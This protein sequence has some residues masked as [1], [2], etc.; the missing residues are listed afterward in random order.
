MSD[1]RTRLA[2]PFVALLALAAS[3]G[4]IVNEFTYDDR[5]I[6]ELNPVMRS[7]HG[8]WRVFQSSY[9]PKEWG[10]DGY[11][12]LTI[13]A[14]KIQ[15]AIGGGRPVV[16]HAANIALYAL[17]SVLVF[18]I[19]RRIL[20]LWAA[21]VVAAL[22]AAHPVHVEAV[23]NVVGQSEL[24][25]ASLL[26]GATLLYLRDRQRGELRPGTLASIV[27]LYVAACF[28]KEH[29]IVLPALL[30]ACELTVV[31]DPA[32]LRARLLTQR[33]L[34]L[35]LAVVAISFVMVRS[36]VLSD[37]ALAGF[38]PFTP[39]ASL[40]IS[41]RDRILTALGVVPQWVRLL[42]WPA[43]L[44]SEYGPPDIEI[45]QGFAFTQLPGLIVLASI[46]GVGFVARRRQPV[47]AFGVALACITLL[48]SSNFV[49]PAGILLAERTL[50]LPSVGA[51]IIVGAV[52]AY[53]ESVARRRHAI[54]SF[55]IAGG[56]VC[57]ALIAAGIVR[58][59]RR[60]R[61]WHDSETLFRQAV[62]DA[63]NAYR[64]HFMLGAWA[65]EHKRQREGERE[66]RR[67]LN[68]FPYDPYVA[69]NLA[70]QYR[71][72][73][74]CGAAVPMYRWIMNMDKNFPLGHTGFSICLLKTGSFVEAKRTALDALR[75]G[76]DSV[77]LREVISFA[78]SAAAASAA[79]KTAGASVRP[80]PSKVPETM[81]K[82]AESASARRNR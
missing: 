78:D 50:F 7:L 36:T 5:Y 27:L 10:G 41:R 39:F 81:Q 20:P 21:C 43:H 72:S 63:P 54:R 29:G 48:P 56:V 70:E 80:G 9:W 47:I 46:L 44:S 26:L 73:D 79:A 22:F 30:L 15:W 18:F 2:A 51:M 67:S 16:F 37:H 23:A 14:F 66:L 53:A 61:I 8:W 62:I 57:S 60:A 64:A 45:A 55:A 13:L 74:R 71:Q 76:G 17:V 38:Q 49:L 33:W 40:H 4:S 24:I 11:R 65:F 19:A 1:W 25:V 6:I 42:Y 3:L 68:L 52:V 69:F 35:S 82:T 12:P 28:S 34:Y 77:A 58:S 75:F 59:E 32:T 31:T